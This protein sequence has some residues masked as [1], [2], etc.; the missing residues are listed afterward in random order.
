MELART[1]SSSPAASR[2]WVAG[3]ALLWA[4]TGVAGAVAPAAATAAALAE[5][6]ALIGGLTL[7]AVVLGR[8]GTRVF[9]L[10]RGGPLVVS[11]LALASFQWCFFTGVRGAG[12]GIAS[13]LSATFAPFAG[14]MIAAVRLRERPSLGFT[15]GAMLLLAATSVLAMRSFSG[16]AAAALS[17]VAYAAYAD[18]ASRASAVPGDYDSSLALTAAALLGAAVALAPAA[19]S[20]V[21]GLL[22]IRGV[23][24]TVYLGVIATGLAYAAF[25]RGLR[26]LAT[27]DALAILLVQPLAAAALGWLVLDEAIDG[28]LALATFTALLAAVVRSARV[29]RAHTQEKT[30]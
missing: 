18:A 9:G 10:L 22:S 12:V 13:I 7:A 27:P 25:V 16:V 23:L 28:A 21:P 5:A 19:L 15:A 17:G 1:T 2:S 8:S 14:D 24:V 30:S 6:R 20:G 11:M 29:F 3:A 26:G 4:T